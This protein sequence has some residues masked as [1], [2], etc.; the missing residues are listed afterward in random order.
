MTNLSQSPSCEIITIGSELLLGQII[1]TNTTYLA[2][3]LGDIGISIRYRTTVG[4]HIDEIVMV[5]QRAVERCDM[6]ITTGGLGP[7]RDD[8]TRK[9]VARAAGVEL[10]FRQ[11]LM[12][13][14]TEVFER[15]GFHMT[16]NNRLQ[17]FVPAGSHGIRNPIGTAP[18][19]F[20]EVDGKP[21]ICL[22]GVP[23][24]LKLLLKK[25]V[26]P[27][28][29]E[30]F[31][32]LD[33]RV[34]YRVLKVVGISESKL[35]ILIGDLIVPGKNPEVGLL[36]NQGEIKIRIAVKGQTHDDA[37]TLIGSVAKEIRSRLGDKIYGEE[38]ETLEGV[39]NSLLIQHD[40]TLA[41]LETYS[42]GL[43]A[44]KF[45]T[46]FSPKLVESRVISDEKRLVKWLGGNKTKLESETAMRL[47]RKFKKECG[48]GIGL[49][50]LG[51]PEKNQKAYSVKS[52]VA[53]AG[54]GIEAGLFR[55]MNG[56]IHMLKQFGVITSLDSLRIQLLDKSDCK[57]HK[58]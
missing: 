35:D 28:L 38:N 3:E 45:Y 41:I 15:M 51:F 43:A 17:A 6:V 50:I 47:A 58:T 53:I 52:Y 24:E 34:I 2:Q 9:A 20:R 46:L 13:Q 26:I 14:I 30:H 23:R 12:D 36:S 21:V 19:F 27:L 16:A 32:L 5:I 40:L 25:D 10:E 18:G 29:R 4:D 44:R 8:L 57:I 11:N 37:Q 22:P 42:G 48:S 56:D 49:A 54:D 31:R 33:Q 39:I 55:E 7:T 1:D